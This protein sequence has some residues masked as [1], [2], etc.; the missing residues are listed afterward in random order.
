M[1]VRKHMDVELGLGVDQ[2]RNWIKARCKSVAG[3][4]WV[5]KA[6]FSHE[7]GMVG[8]WLSQTREMLN[9]IQAGEAP[10]R[11]FFDLSEHLVKVKVDGTFLEGKDYLLVANSVRAL[12]EW[13]QFLHQVDYAEY[14]TKLVR[15]LSVDAEVCDRIEAAIDEN[16]EVRDS[17]SPELAAIRKKIG[18]AER[19]ARSTL[20]RI[21]K[22]SISDEHSSEESQVTFRDGR[23]VIP[24]RAEYKRT[25]PGLVHDESATGQTVYLEPSEALELNNEVRELKNR[26]RREVIRILTS[27]ADGLRGQYEALE[28]GSGV[29]AKLDFIHAKATWARD[30]DAIVPKVEKSP[31]I[32]I[33]QGVHPVL[34]Y[35]HQQSGKSVVPLD[36]ELDAKQ[37]MLVISGPNAGGKSVAL[38]TVGL[39]QYLIQCG[40]PVPV[41]ENSSFGLFNN[42][43]L[44]IGDTQSL[45]DD[46]S[47]YSAHLTSM[48]H[49]LQQAG[50]KSLILI[51]EFGKGTEPQFGGAIAESI[52]SQL[53]NQKCF[54]V[55]TTHY[56][57]LKDLADKTGEMVN[58]AM[59][60]DIDRLEPIYQLEIGKPGSSFAFE[61]ASKI[62][63]PDKVVSDAKA[64]MGAGQVDFDQS[65]NKLEK[66]KQRY[67]K[68][69]DRLERD[70]KQAQQVKRDYE[71]LKDMV[72]FERKKIIREAKDEAQCLLKG[73][74]KDIEKTIREIRES[75]AEKKKTQKARAQLSQREKQMNQPQ[76]LPKKKSDAF[77]AGDQVRMDDQE[78]V[79]EIIRIKGSEAEVQFGLMKSFVKVNRL[80]K[81]SATKKA[82][83]KKRSGGYNRLQSVMDFSHELTLI[84]MRAEEALPKLDSFVDQAIMTGANEVRIVHGKGHGILRDLVRNHLS[85][86]P[87][88][89][90][91]SDDHVDRGGSGISILRFR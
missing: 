48:K 80:T 54:G 30:F 11:H 91:I 89:V 68:L 86:H 18:Q 44:D 46:L 28:K 70:Q 16:G 3:A 57:N 55:I 12:V 37:R 8:S 2:V 24:V 64:K 59:K 41:G 47:T 29:L 14:L 83:Q 84:G 6:S 56:Q 69:N 87:H 20:S 81:V 73:A 38:K 26:E 49:F 63:L 45:E 39:L 75:G 9:I 21:L 78:G 71:E 82:N 4:D 33:S 85:H 67:E 1:S 17:A 5:D 13:I 7:Y 74:N 88:I 53:S 51:D 23:L 22:K 66:E 58:G 42:I 31:V 32:R 90:S 40:F 79:G 43:L 65:L 50:R 72:E 10:N 76:V 52:L 61:I 35:N 15:H 60:F 62:G 25:I 27:L 77:A 19:A 36:L 34:W